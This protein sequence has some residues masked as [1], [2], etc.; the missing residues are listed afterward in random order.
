MT[1]TIQGLLTETPRHGATA[2]G[3]YV[4]TLRAGDGCGHPFETRVPCGSG[5]SGAVEA[6]RLAASMRVGEPCVM[7]GQCIRFVADHD[8]ARFVLGMPERVT[9]GGRGVL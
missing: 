3:S 8:I 6:Q 4:V 2:D 9:V 5:P 1:I 7:S